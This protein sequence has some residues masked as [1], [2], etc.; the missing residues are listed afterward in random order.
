MTIPPL[1]WH[2]DGEH[3][4]PLRP[5]LADQHLTV[6]ETYVFV[7][8]QERS[9]ASHNHYFA[10]LADLWGNLPDDMLAEYP[11][12][13]AFRKKLLVRAGYAD[14]R[15]FVC[16]SK[17]EAQRFAA[18]LRPMDE[19]AVVVVREAVVRVYTAQSQSRKAMGAK[20]FQESKEKVLDAARAL[21]GIEE[22]AAA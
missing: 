3:A 15:S 13:E 19:Y 6:G 8:H 20:V 11:N 4:T 9:Q 16:A 7:E 10:L 2:W 12:A 22:K 5:R 1:G 14:E 18:F 21:L 17:A